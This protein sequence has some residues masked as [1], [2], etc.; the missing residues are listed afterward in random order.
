[1]SAAPDIRVPDVIGEVVAWRAWQIVG[2]LDFPRLESATQSSA[3]SGVDAIWP[4][5]R[6]FEARCLADPAHNEPGVEIP[7]EQCSCGIYAAKTL[8]QLSNLSY[9]RYGPVADKVIGEVAFA[10]KVIEGSQGW[11]AERARI[12]QLW[13]PHR[14][15]RFVEPLADAYGVEVGLARLIGGMIEIEGH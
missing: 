5:N 1:M 6:W 15:W 13:V 2:D 10:G 12:K 14:N 9:A 8:A 4:T 11:R 7:V 3:R